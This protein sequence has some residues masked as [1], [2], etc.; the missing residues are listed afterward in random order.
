MVHGLAHAQALTLPPEEW[1]ALLG[2][3][4]FET[5]THL[6]STINI[7]PLLLEQAKSLS[8]R[9]CQDSV[10]AQHITTLV[11]KCREV[12]S[13]RSQRASPYWVVLSKLENAA[14]DKYDDKLFPFALKFHSTFVAVEWIFS[15]AVMLQLMDAALALMAV[16]CMAS[17]E[18]EL[19][20]RSDAD[21]VARLLC[22]SFEFCYTLESEIFASQAICT[23]QLAVRQYFRRRQLW[24]ELEWC[25]SLGAA[26]KRS[27]GKLELMVFGTDE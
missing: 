9:G 15:S 19:Q 22:Q 6:F 3:A 26:K 5:W 21:Q 7:V 23:P 18:Y 25:E 11:R 8:Q 13:W 20:V 27:Q 14:D 2:P 4:K 16:S 1:Y 12:D 17:P 10:T 24:R